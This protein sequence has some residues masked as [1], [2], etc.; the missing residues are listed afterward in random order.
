MRNKNNNIFKCNEDSIIMESTRLKPI[1]EIAGGRDIHIEIL[2]RFGEKALRT[3]K[4]TGI[5]LLVSEESEGTELTF[6]IDPTGFI[7]IYAKQGNILNGFIDENA[8]K[9]IKTG[10]E[11]FYY[12]KVDDKQ[13]IRFGIDLTYKEQ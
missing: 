1:E 7:K 10:N 9:T 8:V 5:Q 3:F 4:K 13:S 2:N 6:E 11:K 12:L